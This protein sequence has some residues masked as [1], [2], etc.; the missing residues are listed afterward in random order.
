MSRRRCC[1]SAAICGSCSPLP[2][3]WLTRDYKLYI[4]YMTPVNYG[5]VSSVPTGNYTGPCDLGNPYWSL[6][7]C[8]FDFTSGFL[9][10]IG[11]ELATC[12]DNPDFCAKV[13]SYP[14][15]I[16]GFSTDNLVPSITTSTGVATRVY[17]FTG[18]VGTNTW[19]IDVEVRRCM[20]GFGT[21]CVDCTNRTVVT[22]VYTYGNQSYYNNNCDTVLSNG[23]VRQMRFEYV[24]DPYTAAEGIGKTCYLRYWSMAGS[25]AFCAPETGARQCADYCALGLCSFYGSGNFPSTVEIT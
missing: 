15:S 22:L 24:S 9:Y 14:R 6:D 4:P 16:G 12:T 3:D 25:T 10:D 2:S 21:I 18:P 5:R 19:S 13:I 11:N 23:V 7:P 1:C 20:G 8:G 17:N